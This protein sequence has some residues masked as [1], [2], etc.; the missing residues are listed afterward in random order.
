MEE[1]TKDKQTTNLDN[2]DK[3]F[4]NHAFNPIYKKFYRKF[5][6]LELLFRIDDV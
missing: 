5:K 1:T 3:V 4:V 6:N 2:L